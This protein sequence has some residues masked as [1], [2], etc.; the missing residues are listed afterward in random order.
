M[1]VVDDKSIGNSYT[2]YMVE[3]CLPVSGGTPQTAMVSQELVAFVHS[4]HVLFYHTG[5]VDL[6]YLT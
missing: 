1:P 4:S 2:Q 3:Q 6:L 5:D